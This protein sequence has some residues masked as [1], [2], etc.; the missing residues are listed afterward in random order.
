MKKIILLSVIFLRYAQS[1]TI[2]DTLFLG[3]EKKKVMTYGMIAYTA[4][5]FYVEYNWWW[6]GNYHEFVFENDGFWNNY[7]LGVDKFGHFYA[8]YLYFHFTYDILRW[9][10]FTEETSLWLAIAFPAFNALSVEIGDGYS[11]FAFS[12]LD[13]TTNMLGIGYS[14]LQKEVPFFENFNFKWSYYPSGTIPFDGKFRITDDYDG[15]IYWL[16]FNIH[17]LLPERLREYYPRWLTFAVGYGG[18]NISARPALIGTPIPFNGIPARKWAFSIDY[19]LLELPLEGGLWNP[20][21]S[22]LNNFK[23]P[24]PGV[25]QIQ[26]QKAEFK[27]LLVN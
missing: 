7:S 21:K 8:S 25:R 14:V 12:A 19:N 26:N 13:L 9:A 3:A 6:K 4:A 11:T 10:N 17:G 1:Q 2:Q 18:K 27:P 23:L 22:L 16:S 5:S 15:H 24:A 20:L